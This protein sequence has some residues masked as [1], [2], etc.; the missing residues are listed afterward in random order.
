MIPRYGGELQSQLIPVHLIVTSYLGIVS[1]PYASWS[2][3]DAAEALLPTREH[4]SGIMYSTI[5]TNIQVRR[6]GPWT[7]DIELH[8]TAPLFGE[9]D[10]LALGI[11]TVL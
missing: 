5:P 2:K 9:V 1:T 10:A 11:S 4:Q 6:R 3:K 8:Q 7:E